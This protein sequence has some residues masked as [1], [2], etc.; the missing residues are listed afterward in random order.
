MGMDKDRLQNWVVPLLQVQ[1]VDARHRDMRVP[2]DAMDS[3][4]VSTWYGNKLWFYESLQGLARLDARLIE[5]DRRLLACANRDQYY[6]DTLTDQVTLSGLW[7]MGAY[8]WLRTFKDRLKEFKHPQQKKFAALCDRFGTVRVPLAKFESQRD[9][10]NR[11]L[12]GYSIARP[13][14]SRGG[15]GWIVDEGVFI[16]RLELANDLITALAEYDPFPGASE[17]FPRPPKGPL[18]LTEFLCDEARPLQAQL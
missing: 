17:W 11:K 15:T 4:D 6:A 14:T 5:D 1:H 18:N 12:K 9:K 16:S 2:V 10:G 7:L 13:A 3:S 8:E